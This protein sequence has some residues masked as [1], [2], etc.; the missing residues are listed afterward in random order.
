MF[1]IG[2]KLIRIQTGQKY[3]I[4][5]VDKIKRIGSLFKKD[6]WYSL[7][8]IN[9][10]VDLMVRDDEIKKLFAPIKKTNYDHIHSMDMKEL[11]K[12][13]MCPHAMGDD[14]E[15]FAKSIGSNCNECC[16]K[17]LQSEVEEE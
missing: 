4:E 10:N 15:E 6:T 13:I 8:Q 12:V 11:A 5:S 16:L 2:A 1:E 7:K 14:C 17:W 9:G 3:V